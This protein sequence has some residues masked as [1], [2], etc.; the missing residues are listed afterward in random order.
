MPD[1]PRLI[2]L[3]ELAEKL[4]VSSH[5]IRHWVRQGKLKP[6]RVCRRLLFHPGEIARF[7]TDAQ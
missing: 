2:T 3:N 7:L 4:R 5:T 6:V 1:L